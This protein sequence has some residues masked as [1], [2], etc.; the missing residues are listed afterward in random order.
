[1][2][3]TLTKAQQNY[4]QIEKEALALVTAV[5]RFRKFIFGR[6]FVLQTD[7]RPLLALF[8]TTK[9]LDTR[10]ANRLKRWALRLI[11]YD[12]EIEYVKTENFGQ[13]DALS[14]LIQEDRQEV[15]PD[16]EEVIASL[17]EEETEIFQMTQES[18][19]LLPQVNRQQL[20]QAIFSDGVL[21]EVIDRL[22]TGWLRSDAK[23]KQLL[24]YYRRRERLSVVEK[25]LVSDDRVVILRSMRHIVLKTLHIAHPGIRR[26]VQLARR[27]FYWPAMHDDIEAFVKNCNHCSQTAATPP[28]E[29]L[30]PRSDSKKSWTQIHIDFAGP[31]HNQW[32]LIVVDSYSK[33]VDAACFST[34][35]TAATCRYLR[36]LFCRYGP[37]EVL[38]SDNGTQFTSVDFAQL[39]SDFNILHL[40]SPPGHPQS[41]GQA[42]RMVGTM[43]RSMCVDSTSP[44]EEELN[45]FVL[46]EHIKADSEVQ[47][48][49]RCLK[50]Y[51]QPWQQTHIDGPAPFVKNCSECRREATV[52][53][54]EAGSNP[55]SS[56]AG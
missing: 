31:I 44:L 39:C 33:F 50:H 32:I 34:I 9:G 7:H 17:Q 11:G 38:V 28:K 27:Y 30:H 13:A 43:K 10:T 41:N 56:V 54:I 53:I 29:P 6:H 3:K 51:N 4:S 2:S 15:D 25:I 47:Q 8:R 40:R 35:T 22:Q 42:E 48:Y 55:W 45:R 20:Q 36:R 5:E 23:D 18:I 26:M 37:P 1:M 12:F 14:R 24:P 49:R 52:A 16:L 19:K 21:A 46:S